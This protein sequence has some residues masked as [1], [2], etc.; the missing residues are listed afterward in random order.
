MPKFCY[1]KANML[2]F[3]QLR[4]YDSE[5]KNRL[6]FSIY[7]IFKNVFSVLHPVAVTS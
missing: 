1:Q 3:R 2:V 6:N 5:V 7:F 4:M